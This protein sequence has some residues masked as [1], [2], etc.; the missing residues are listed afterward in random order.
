[1]KTQSQ[2]NFINPDG[3]S[4]AQ[5]SP[6]MARGVKNPLWFQLASRVKAAREAADMAFVDVRNLGGIHMTTLGQ[7]ERQERIPRLDTIERIAAAL[8]VSACWMTFGE[9]G[10]NPFKARVS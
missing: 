2:Q 4:R 8:G 10:K 6:A 5:F 1:M 3:K 9:D 7:V